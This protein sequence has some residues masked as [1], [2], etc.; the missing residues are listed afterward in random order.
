MNSFDELFKAFGQVWDELLKIFEPLS[1]IFMDP[2]KYI[3][4]DLKWKKIRK[5]EQENRKYMDSRYKLVFKQ[6]AL[7]KTTP[8]NLPYQRRNY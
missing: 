7:I 1:D 4:P 3:D 2:P 8:K 5:K 6:F